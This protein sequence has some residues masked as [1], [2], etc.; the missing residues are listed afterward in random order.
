MKMAVF[1]DVA[2]C[3]LVDTDRR[4]ALMM[5]AVS[6]SETSFTFYETTRCNVPQDSQSFSIE[7]ERMRGKSETLVKM[8]Q[9]ES[10]RTGKK[11]KTGARMTEVSYNRLP[12]ARGLSYSSIPH[13]FQ[14]MQA[15]DRTT[16]V[17]GSFSY[18]S[19]LPL[20]DSNYEKTIWLQ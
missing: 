6:I 9:W 12:Y 2:P 14:T 1:W 16:T 18:C 15:L 3:S 19:D 13:R 20:Q 17:N 11:K 7:V 4:F 10:K 5:E 8:S